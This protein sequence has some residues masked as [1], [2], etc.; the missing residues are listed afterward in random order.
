MKLKKTVYRYRYNE[1]THSWSVIELC[2]VLLSGTRESYNLSDT[3]NRDANV[4]LRVLGDDSA[5]V[6]P[7]D[8]ITFER[9]ENGTPEAFSNLVVVAVFR[10]SNGTKRVRHTKILCK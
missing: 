7:Q 2:N 9:A 1:N 5:D 3:L 10:N 6:S 8:V 4:V